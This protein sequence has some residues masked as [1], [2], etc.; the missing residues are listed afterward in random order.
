MADAF[1]R[2][3]VRLS[4]CSSHA[5]KNNALIDS[6]SQ[7]EIRVLIHRYSL[8]NVTLTVANI[9]R[10]DVSIQLNAFYHPRKNEEVL[11]GH[12]IH[13]YPYYSHSLIF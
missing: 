12:L 7:Y 5:S 3:L 8:I 13:I 6:D 2:T 4:A 1:P 11:T 9:T 10:K